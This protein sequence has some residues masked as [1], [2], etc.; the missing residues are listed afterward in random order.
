MKIR[1]ALLKQMGLAPPYVQ[2]QPLTIA[3]LELGDPG[4]GEVL[5]SMR[6]AGLC[7]SDLSV[8]DGVRPRTMPMVLGHEAVGVIEKLGDGVTDLKVGDHVV[9]VFVPSC[10]HCQ[11]CS[12]GRPALCEPGFK[13]NVAGTLLTG[14]RRFISPK[15]DGQFINHHLGVSGFADHAVVARES[16]VR[17][18]PKLPFDIAAVFGCAVITGVGAV[19]NT[20][21]VKSGESVAVVGLGGVGLAALLGAK[22]AGAT[23]LIAIDLSD[24]KLAI[25]KQFGATHTFNASQPDCAEQVRALLPGGVTHALEMA[26]SAKA[27][28]LAWKITARGGSTVTAGLPHPDARLSISPAQLVVEERVL[29]GSYVG[30][31]VP[32]R[33]IPL[34]IEWY[35]RGELPVD[36]LLSERIR[37]SDINAGFDRLAAGQTIRQVIVFD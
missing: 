31:C 33:D 24:S 36:K 6:A 37:L 11:P 34:Y 3:E 19:V 21:Q 1:A 35:L 17:I 16:C 30:G 29:K 15:V 10:G 20:A 23:P 32:S 25:A 13:A 28:E 27:L 14:A 26:G 8:I 2:S 12:H 4:P 5:V 18:D 22:R 9:T 7:H